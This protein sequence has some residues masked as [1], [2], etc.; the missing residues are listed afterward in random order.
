MRSHGLHRGRKRET[1]PTT[2]WLSLTATELS[3]AGLVAQGLS[4][5]QIAARLF[6]SRYTVETHLKHIFG[7]LGITSRTML[8]NEVVKHSAP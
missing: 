6:I 8:T 2:G 1:R 3:V 5:P 4:N 7:K